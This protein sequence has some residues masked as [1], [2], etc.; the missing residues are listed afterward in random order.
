MPITGPRMVLRLFDNNGKRAETGFPLSAVATPEEAAG[1]IRDF[2]AAV[3]PLTNAVIR[4]AYYTHPVDILP[5]PTAQPESNVYSRLVLLF[6]DAAR[7]GVVSLPSPA[8]LPFDVDGPYRG[9]RLQR[10]ALVLL[11]VLAP[12]ETAVAG[13]SLPDGTAFPSAYSVGGIT[14]LEEL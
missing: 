5:G 11:G 10:E 12:L 2:A 6:R 9:I 8:Q 13:C 14:T 4:E 7:Y 1:Y 3:A